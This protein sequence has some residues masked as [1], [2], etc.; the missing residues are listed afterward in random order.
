MSI[1]YNPKTSQFEEWDEFAVSGERILKDKP[2][3]S[4]KPINLIEGI[5]NGP[6]RGNDSRRE[7]VGDQSG[8]EQTR[9]SVKLGQELGYR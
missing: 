2:V 8:F 9:G 6:K 4:Q 5:I 3:V 1:Y 7:R